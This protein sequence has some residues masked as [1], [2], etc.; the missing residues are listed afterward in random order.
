MTTK[1]NAQNMVASSNFNV[2]FIVEGGS[3][4]TAPLQCFN[5]DMKIWTIN[6]AR[7]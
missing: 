6:F 1:Q 4:N 2:L 5:Y 3:I 7:I